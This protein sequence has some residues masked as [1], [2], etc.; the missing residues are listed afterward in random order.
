MKYCPSCGERCS[1]KDRFCRECGTDFS[2]H[3]TSS[4]KNQDQHPQKIGTVQQLRNSSKGWSIL[5][6]HTSL[7]ETAI[8]LCGL[9]LVALVFAPWINIQGGDLVNNL[10]DSFGAGDVTPESD[11]AGYQTTGG[12][13]T[14]ATATFLLVFTWIKEWDSTAALGTFMTG[15]FLLIGPVWHIYALAQA[16]AEAS[17]HIFREAQPIEMPDGTY[18]P[19]EAVEPGFGVGW[20]LILPVVIMAISFVYTLMA[21]FTKN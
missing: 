5:K 12:L 6:P 1:N 3:S 4:E 18:A 10:A 17:R 13:I 21:V 2:D 8:V 9:A 19:I 11:Y 20:A 14:L 15:L 16:E 7:A